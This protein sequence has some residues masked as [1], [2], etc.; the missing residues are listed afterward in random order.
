MHAP[1]PHMLSLPHLQHPLAEWNVFLTKM[2]LCW[3][4]KITPS[5]R[6]TLGFT[7][8][9]AYS[10]DLDICIIR[11]IHSY[12]LIQSIFTALTMLFALFISSRLHPRQPSIF[13]CLHSFT[14]PRTSYSWNHTIYWLVS[15]RKKMFLFR[16]VHFSYQYAFRVPLSSHVL[17]IQFFLK[18]N[19]SSFSRCTAVYLSIHFLKVIFIASQ[20]GQ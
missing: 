16:L 4:I 8:D 17:V 11:Y 3:H 2:Y 9:I 18:L 10:M 19:S 15:F 12:I 5:Q 6:F 20:L 7:F 13:Y 1:F 14:F